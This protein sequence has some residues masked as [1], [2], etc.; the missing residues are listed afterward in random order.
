MDLNELVNLNEYSKKNQA[1]SR[2]KDNEKSQGFR[3]P[4][5]SI[6]Y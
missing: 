6:F 1:Y 5:K 3:S 4:G 2:Y